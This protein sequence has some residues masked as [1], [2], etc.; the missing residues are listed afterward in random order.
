MG[1]QIPSAQKT[2]QPA[3]PAPVSYTHLDVYKRQDNTYAITISAGNLIFTPKIIE[4]P[5]GAILE[6]TLV[7]EDTMVHDLKFAN[8][9]R[10]GRV[11]CLL[12]TSRCV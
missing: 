10:T 11:A 12:Y 4:V 9:V 6:V 7:N 8:G 1:R 3:V 2:P 5:A